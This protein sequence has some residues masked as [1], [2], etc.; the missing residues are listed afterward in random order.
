[1][2]MASDVQSS[3]AVL[4]EYVK[5]PDPIKTGRY[6]ALGQPS[7]TGNLFVTVRDTAF[8]WGAFSRQLAAG[9]RGEMV[10]INVPGTFLVGASFNEWDPEAVEPKI[11]SALFSLISIQRGSGIARVVGRN[12][13][14]AD[15][16]A[17]AGIVV[18]DDASY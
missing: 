14:Q 11:G 7:A 6:D 9:Q 4:V 18:A 10:F 15:L 17:G 8:L 1:V 13:S 2:D 3:P 12:C 16:W 5:L